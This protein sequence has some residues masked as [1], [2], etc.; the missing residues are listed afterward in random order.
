[1][2]CPCSSLVTGAV[3]ISD[4]STATPQQLSTGGGEEVDLTGT[5]FGAVGAFNGTV[6]YSNGVLTYT[7]SC[8][9][10]TTDTQLACTTVPGVGTGF[11]W[12]VRDALGSTATTAATTSYQPPTFSSVSLLSGSSSLWTTGNDSLVVAGAAFGPTSVTS[13][14][15]VVTY[16]PYTAT[17]CVVSQAQ[18]TLTCSAVAGVGGSLAVTVTVAGQAASGG[19]GVTV[20][21]LPPSI[22]AVSAA[23]PLATL[24]GAAVSLTGWNFGTAVPDSVTLTANGVELALTG[25]SVTTPHR[26]LQ[27]Q[28]PASYGGTITSWAVSVSQQVGRLTTS[29]V[30]FAGPSITWW[31]SPRR[32]WTRRAVRRC[33]CRAAT[34]ARR[35][36]SR[37]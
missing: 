17:G 35:V 34:S 16:G 12:T 14:S 5:G 36:R 11:V 9:V 25:C 2:S 10:A 18:T 15:L 37:W 29:S 21:Y 24:G 8:V 27:C 4:L 30:T 20:S 31:W 28:S 1:M 22:S 33:G 3:S 7:A 23:G 13:G 32:R 19:G 6:S 26:A